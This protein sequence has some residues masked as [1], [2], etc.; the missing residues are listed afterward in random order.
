MDL[1]RAK[2]SRAKTYDILRQTQLLSVTLK[3][4]YKYSFLLIK[5]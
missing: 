2:S 5:S 4:F 3:K 1:K